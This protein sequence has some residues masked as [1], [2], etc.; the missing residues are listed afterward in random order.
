MKALRLL[1][2]AARLFAYN[3]LWRH[4]GLRSAGRALVCALESPDEDLQTIAGT[5]LAQAGKKA[6]PLLQEAL[7]RRTSLPMIL[8]I[9]G[10]IG[11]WTLEPQLRQ[12]SKDRDPEVAQA[13]QDALRLL[14]AHR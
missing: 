9:L 6:E 7:N 14:E 3:A 4:T 13:A 12:F 8:T 5:F 10:D 11:D 1:L 2:P